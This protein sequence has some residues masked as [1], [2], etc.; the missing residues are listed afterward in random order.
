M[1]IATINLK[2]RQPAATGSASASRQAGFTLV[3]V[4]VSLLIIGLSLGS[5]LSLYIQ[6]AIRSDWSA[7]SVAAQM[8]AVGGMEQCR[9]SKFDP[10]GGTDNLQSTNF[11]SKV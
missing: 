3:E 8:M 5:I 9:A 11:P 2:Q 10:R 4:L 1:R 7:T 6:S